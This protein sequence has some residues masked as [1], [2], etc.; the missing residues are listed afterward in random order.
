MLAQRSEKVAASPKRRVLCVD[1]YSDTCDLIKLVLSQY[2]V[3]AAYTKADGFY[4][5]STELFDLIILDHHLPDGTGLE[6]CREIRA[7]NPIVPILFFTGA[8]DLT[9]QDVVSAGGQLMIDKS[10][11]TELLPGVA[12][13]LEDHA[14]Q[15]VLRFR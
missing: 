14:V 1:D 10:D 12:S 6:L 9:P 3:V 11:L 2:E 4:L 8:V 15:S 13:V 7:V 5:A